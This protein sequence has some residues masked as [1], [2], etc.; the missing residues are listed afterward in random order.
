MQ[1]RYVGDIGDYVKLSIL[2]AIMPG[3]RL[4]VAWWLFPD[5]DHNSDGVHIAY[6][7]EAARWRSFDPDLFDRLRKVVTAGER[8]VEALQHADV[9]PGGV[10]CDDR[11]PTTGT[12][13][14]RMLAREQWFRR[15]QSRVSGCDLVFIDPD[16][17]LETKRFNSGASKA[18]KSV[19]LAEL[20]AL[21]SPER[22]LIVYHHHT[23]M[24]GGHHHE[25]EHWGERLRG[26]G[27]L[28]VDA[29]RASAYSARAFFILDASHGVRHRA[30]QIAARWGERLLTWHPRLGSLV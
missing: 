9:L 23:R 26:A 13:G 11:I 15:V 21:R 18:G 5:E 24:K 3:R 19:S 16:N 6:L 8:R 29:L 20:Q 12:P 22:T 7:D 30:E 2:R 4:G 14:Q 10:Y 25:L 17:G 28:T 27:F 1:D